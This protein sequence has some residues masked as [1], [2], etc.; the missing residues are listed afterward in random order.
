[1]EQ[2]PLGIHNP[3][4]LHEEVFTSAIGFIPTTPVLFVAPLIFLA[5]LN[6]ISDSN[7]GGASK[8]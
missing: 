1:M 7:V 6:P 3:L 8:E 2:V 5:T 4:V